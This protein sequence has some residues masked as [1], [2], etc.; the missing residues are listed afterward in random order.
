MTPAEK[1][2]LWNCVMQMRSMPWRGPRGG[3]NNW[4]QREM[5][6][7]YEKLVVYGDNN[8]PDAAWR[9]LNSGKYKYMIYPWKKSL[10]YNCISFEPPCVYTS[11]NATVTDNL[12]LVY[13]G[14]VTITDV[15]TSTVLTTNIWE[16][17][18]TD[19]QD[20]GY[21]TWGVLYTTSSTPT[22]ATFKLI[23]YI[24]TTSVPNWSVTFDVNSNVTTF[25]IEFLPGVTCNPTYISPENLTPWLF[26][27]G[28]SPSDIEFTSFQF[29]SNTGYVAAL[30]VNLT[31][32]VR[33]DNFDQV[34]QIARAIS[35]PQITLIQTNAQNG[36]TG[37]FYTVICGAYTC[38]RP[39]KFVSVKIGGGT[40]NFDGESYV[41]S[42]DTPCA[43]C[44]AFVISVGSGETV[45][46]LPADDPATWTTTIA[47]TYGCNVL[48]YY[49]SSFSQ[50]YV[51]LVFTSVSY[52]DILPIY[53]EP[54]GPYTDKT[55][56]NTI[57]SSCDPGCM[58]VI[59]P[60]FDQYIDR[61]NDV[62]TINLTDFNG[63][64]YVDL[65]DTVT[66][67]SILTQIYSSLYGPACYVVVDFTDIFDYRI[68]VYNAYTAGAGSFVAPS[69]SSPL[70]A[71]TYSFTQIPCP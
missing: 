14:T 40:P 44:Y 28:T 4:T 71:T 60:A 2:Q 69:V 16:R 67:T 47:S 24:N 12:S 22:S 5:R 3:V 32:P 11:N 1:E 53:V 39:A 52:A 23:L 36:T 42:C 33:I 9:L 31:L 29:S 65:A 68:T 38:A 49:D 8:Q 27:G 21:D 34:Q 50:V 7:L 43:S 70:T 35:G 18:F 46:G 25:P 45:D 37:E 10:I 30:A 54:S 19:L 62:S 58:E 51:I 15:D 48:A 55:V 13:S 66:A 57:S 20:L 64:G 59:I 26:R 6:K 61:L 41:T 56:Y 17:V 63:G